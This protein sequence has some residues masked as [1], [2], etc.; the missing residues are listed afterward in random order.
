MNLVPTGNLEKNNLGCFFFFALLIPSDSAWENAS[1][2]N[3]IK[4]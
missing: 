3:S 1:L 4:N 2:L